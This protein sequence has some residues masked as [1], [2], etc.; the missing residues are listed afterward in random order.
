MHFQTSTTLTLAFLSTT[1]AFSNGTLLPA[2]LCSTNTNDGMPKSLGGVLQFMKHPEAAGPIIAKY[3]N[4][5][6]IVAQ[7]NVVKTTSTMKT[8]TPGASVPLTVNTAGTDPAAPLIGVLLY[9]VDDQGQKIGTFTKMGPNMSP[10]T[11][12]APPGSSDV[13]GIVQTVPLDD[14]KNKDIANQE[15]GIVWSAPSVMFTR[16]VTFKGLAVTD[17]GFGFHSSMFEV[18]GGLQ[19]PSGGS[20]MLNAPVPNRVLK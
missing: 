7:N 5:D 4:Q 13:V 10:F 11:P 2:Y 19:V 12:C 9:A 3:H 15:G 14:G 20:W 6:S 1:S 8:L 16:T 18:Q 17:T